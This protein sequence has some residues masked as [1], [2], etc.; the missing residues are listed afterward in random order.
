MVVD[1]VQRRQDLMPLLRVLLGRFPLAERIIA[2]GLADLQEI[3][4]PR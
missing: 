3:L 2:A 4:S 1:E